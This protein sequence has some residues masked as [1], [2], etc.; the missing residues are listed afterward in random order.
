MDFSMEMEELN[1][2]MDRYFKEL[3]QKGKNIWAV[4][5]IQMVVIMMACSNKTYQMEQVNFIGRM[6]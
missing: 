3:L 6:A 1:I 4:I 2:I 5:H